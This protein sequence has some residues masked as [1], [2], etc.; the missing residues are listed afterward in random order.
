MPKMPCRMHSYG[1]SGHLTHSQAL[2]R[3][4]GFW[5]S[6]ATLPTAPWML[7]SGRGNLITL[8]EELSLGD[9]VGAV[10]QEPSPEA[11]VIVQEG[12]QHFLDA[13]TKLSPI[14]RD[15]LVLREMEGLSYAE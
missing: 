7:V 13:L 2:R 6:Y 5:P 12:Q 15:I 3:A 4:P 10:S 14:H 8:R 1:P 11:V 9:F